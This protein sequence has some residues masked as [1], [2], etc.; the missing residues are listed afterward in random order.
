[1]L[2]KLGAPAARTRLYDVPPKAHKKIEAVFGAERLHYDP[3]TETLALP[4][5]TRGMTWE[6][7]DT[8]LKALPDH[9]LRHT[10]DRGFLEIMSPK[11]EHDKLKKIIGRFIENM[12]LTLG[13][14]IECSGSAT[15]RRKLL[16]RGLEPDETYFIANE[17][18]VRGKLE[19]D[20][21]VDPPPDLAI[22]VDL[23][24]PSKRRM[25][26]YASLGIPELW[27]YNGS[28][29]QFHLLGPKRAYHEV[30]RSQS[31]PFLTP[32]DL[33]RYLNRLSHEPTDDLIIAF[34][35]WAKAEYK[36]IYPPK[37]RKK[38]SS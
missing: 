2:R 6:Q 24:R 35:N 20:A 30:D 14:H 1:M 19:W 34:A 38:K 5:R 32:S 28:S 26:I 27:T 8:L 23:R 37:Q 33:E 15:F 11:H 25:R 9:R 22:E 36:K 16:D 10:Y 29:M 3:E 21:N 18:A 13:I 31:F 12:T 17:P 7:Y 4:S